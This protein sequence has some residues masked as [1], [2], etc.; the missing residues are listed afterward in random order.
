MATQDDPAAG[1]PDGWYDLHAELTSQLSLIEFVHAGNY[2]H[3]D[4]KPDNFLV[5]CGA[6]KN[7][8]YIIDFGLAKRYYDP[9]RDRHIRYRDGKRLTGTARYASISTHMGYG[10]LQRRVGLTAEQSRRDDLESLAYVLIYF[11]RGALPWQGTKGPTAK[12]RRERILE[13]KYDTPVPTLCQGH[14]EEFASFLTYVR[15]LKFEATP[16]YA[17]LRSLLNSLMERLGIVD[18]GILQLQADMPLLVDDKWG[19][20]DRW[21]PLPH[22]ETAA[23]EG[24]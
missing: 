10:R 18:D 1:Y 17:Y 23:F 2:I 6:H 21:E 15:E 16:D 4:V 13:K 8:L 22:Q 3:R 12:F 9:K 24:P 14:P 19:R 7:T 5:G 20:R 11:V